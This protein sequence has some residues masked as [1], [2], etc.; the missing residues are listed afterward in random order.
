M[1][2]TCAT[3]KFE[4]QME[5]SAFFEMFGVRQEV[6]FKSKE[7]MSKNVE[8][9]HSMEMSVFFEEVAPALVSRTD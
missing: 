6:F 8:F 7:M 2:R 9:E 3:K 5:S 4:H 1:M